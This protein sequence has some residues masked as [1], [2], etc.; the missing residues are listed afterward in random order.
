MGES[1]GKRI[2]FGNKIREERGR[3]KQQNERERLN[4]S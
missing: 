2:S 1:D 4:F 3:K